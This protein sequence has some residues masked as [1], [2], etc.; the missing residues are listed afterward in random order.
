M[1]QLL[2]FQEKNFLK[3]NRNAQCERRKYKKVGRSL[4]LFFRDAKAR[5]IENSCYT[6]AARSALPR[7]VEFCGSHELRLAR[8]S[9]P[10]KIFAVY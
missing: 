7:Q 2:F 6:N 5:E 3:G 8:E 1:I 4:S 9:F 10:L